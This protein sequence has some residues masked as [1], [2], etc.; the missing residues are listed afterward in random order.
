[1]SR[2]RP[3]ARPL[4]KDICKAFTGFSK[5][6]GTYS[7]ILNEVAWGEHTIRLRTKHKV[8][9][10]QYIT[11]MSKLSSSLGKDHRWVRRDL[12]VLQKMGIIT[13]EERGKH[14]LVITNTNQVTMTAKQA[15]AETAPVVHKGNERRKKKVPDPDCSL[16]E[17]GVYPKFEPQNEGFTPDSIRGL[18]QIGDFPSLYEK[19][20]LRIIINKKSPMITDKKNSDQRWLQFGQRWHEYAKGTIKTKPYPYWNDKYFAN[21]LKKVSATTG[22]TIEELE[23]VLEFLI[24]DEGPYWKP[25]GTE[26]ISLLNISSNKKR[27]IDNILNAIERAKNGGVKN[28]L[29]RIDY[30]ADN[31][32]FANCND[33]R[34]WDF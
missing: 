5:L 16:N 19:K 15:S 2:K 22:Q 30:S 34:P 25:T 8:E 10:G 31:G 32:K 1:M 14:C 9:V 28:G 29:P 20:R 24:A 27:K 6:L 7:F 26:P 33:A 13:L 11:T 3:S 17:H 12:A 21:A 18:P 4:F 23:S